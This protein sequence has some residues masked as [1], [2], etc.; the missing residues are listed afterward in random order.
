MATKNKCCYLEYIDDPWCPSECGTLASIHCDRCKSWY[1][2]SHSNSTICHGCK[3]LDREAE[4]TSLSKRSNHL[5]LE[6]LRL[7]SDLPKINHVYVHYKGGLY[8]VITNA[9]LEA[10]E[11]ICVVYTDGKNAF[12][13]PYKEWKEVIHNS[14]GTTTPRFQLK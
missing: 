4:I 13:R 2:N 7:R 8:T 3:R 5:G 14:D 6:D 1:C 12:V 10:T 9:Y 11:E